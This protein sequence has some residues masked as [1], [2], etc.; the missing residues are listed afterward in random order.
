MKKTRPAVELLRG[1]EFPHR[2][3]CSFCGGAAPFDGNY[4]DELLG[5]RTTC[6]LG[7]ALESLGEDGVWSFKNESPARKRHLA[8]MGEIERV[9]FKTY[10][11]RLIANDVREE[12]AKRK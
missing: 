6:R 8:A 4:L 1:M 12:L 11:A 2:G 7:K 9:G 10:V 5:H 3:R